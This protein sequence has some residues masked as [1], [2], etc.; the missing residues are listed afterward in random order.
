MPQPSAALAAP[1]TQTAIP[2]RRAHFES[3][4]RARRQT[5]RSRVANGSPPRVEPAASD[6][7]FLDGTLEPGRRISHSVYRD[8]RGRATN[9]E[10]F[11]LSKGDLAID[12]L[13]FILV[14][15]ALV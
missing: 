15:V 2:T 9:D 1:K 5:S 4:G 6:R 8:A 12:L 11:A 13:I 3:D 10:M 14:L 7:M